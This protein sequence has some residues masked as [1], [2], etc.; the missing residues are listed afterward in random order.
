MNSLTKRT[1]SYLQ[2]P[3]VYCISAC[4]CGNTDVQWSEYEKHIWCSKCEIDF[5]PESNGI[6]DGPILLNVTQMLGINFTK[7]NLISNKVSILDSD[8][9][10]MECLNFE[11]VFL[12]QLIPVNIKNI[13][14][15]TIGMAHIDYQKFELKDIKYKDFV[16]SLDGSEKLITTE[17]VFNFPDKDIFILR[18]NI[19]NGVIKLQEDTQSDNFKKYILKEHL[20]TQLMLKSNSSNRKI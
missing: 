20:Q 16:S 11:D 3:A 6:F 4:N 18:W 1:F 5:I 2:Q 15:A 12:S 17:F 19:L 10:Y 9:D 8:I 7:L 13:N 14:R